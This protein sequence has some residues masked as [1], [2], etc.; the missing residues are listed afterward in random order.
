[1]C[2][3]YTGTIK[4][5]VLRCNLEQGRY[6]APYET[7][8]EHI[9]SVDIDKTHLLLGFGGHNGLF[10]CWDP[11]DRRRVGI[12][13][14]YD[15]APDLIPTP[16]ITKLKFGDDG[17]SLAVGTS[18]GHVLMYDLR[19]NK[20]LY[21]LNHRNKIGIK[22]IH[23]HNHSDKVISCDAKTIRF[24]N[25]YSGRD[26]SDI[27]TTTYP[28]VCLFLNIGVIFVAQEQHRIGAYY[29][30]SLGVA[31]KWCPFLDNMTEELEENKSR[32]IYTD[33]KFVPREEIEALGL[34]H[35]IGTN[36]L[37][38]YMHGFFM[39]TRL[40]RRVRALVNPDAYETFL[41]EK[42]KEKISQERSNRIVI[43][44]KPPAVNSSYFKHLLSKQAE[45]RPKDKKGD[46]PVE[47]NTLTDPRF[48][49]MFKNKDYEIDM[50]NDIYLKYHPEI[51][52]AL[53]EWA[54]DNLNEQDEDLKRYMQSERQLLG[55]FML[56]QLLEEQDEN[57]ENGEKQ[58]QEKSEW[59]EI[60]KNTQNAY[61]YKDAIEDQAKK[62]EVYDM[63]KFAE[64]YGS[65]NDETEMRTLQ[66][67]GDED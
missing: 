31:P 34:E 11:R 51:K 28:F 23:F 44:G 9:S 29:V 38:P 14:L 3:L 66:L 45:Y 49:D 26:T 65:D 30:P 61:K 5:L 8:I 52:Y 18:G 46:I 58:D 4:N 59:E 64:D 55:K 39:D 15:S 22:D 57:D 56:P 13:D 67:E 63:N 19:R 32:A 21:T 2:E 54:G 62:D 50:E 16:D 1:M 42:T 33:Y 37:K 48:N 27:I 12:I 60:R 6:F 53:H 47:M 7:S 43:E 36:L 40:Y 10:E 24:W 20:P 35:I 17:L 25:K 41:K